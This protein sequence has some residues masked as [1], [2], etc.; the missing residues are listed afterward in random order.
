MPSTLVLQPVRFRGGVIAATKTRVRNHAIRPSTTL[1]SAS[2][3]LEWIANALVIMRRTTVGVSSLLQM[4]FTLRKSQRPMNGPVVSIST[5]DE[6]GRE[7]LGIGFATTTRRIRL[8]IPPLLDQAMAFQQRRR[9][10]NCCGTFVSRYC[11]LF[12]LMLVQF[13]RL[14]CCFPPISPLF[15]FLHPGPPWQ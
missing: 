13:Q 1:F 6:F 4:E 11:R 3:S 5:V 14:S 15:H 2:F 7:A 10:K 8:S 9:A 12:L